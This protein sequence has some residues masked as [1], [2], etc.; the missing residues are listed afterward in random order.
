MSKLLCIVK[1]S[2]HLHTAFKST[3]SS[4]KVDCSWNLLSPT[5]KQ[6]HATFTVLYDLNVASVN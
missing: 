5:S 4:S 6:S 3:M 1:F 2:L